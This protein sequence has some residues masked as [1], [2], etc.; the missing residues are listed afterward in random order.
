MVYIHTMTTTN[1]TKRTT[2]PRPFAVWTKLDFG[3]N[4]KCVI[5]RGA[6]GYTTVHFATMEAAERFAASLP[7]YARM[8]NHGAFRFA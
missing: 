2:H 8:P 5:G 7:E 3:A 6:A 1:E 4:G